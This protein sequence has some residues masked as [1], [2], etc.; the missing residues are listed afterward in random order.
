MTFRQNRA[1]VMFGDTRNVVK[2]LACGSWFYN[3]LVSLPTSRVLYFADKVIESCALMLKYKNQFNLSGWIASQYNGALFTK[4]HTGSSYINPLGHSCGRFHCISAF[5]LIV[6]LIQH[7]WNHR[8]PSQTAQNLIFNGRSRLNLP[9]KI[10]SCLTRMVSKIQDKECKLNLFCLPCISC[11]N[12]WHLD[13]LR[14]SVCRVRNARQTP[15]QNLSKW[16][17]IPQFTPPR[18]QNTLILQSLSCLLETICQT[19][20][21]FGR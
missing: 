11:D 4:C 8:Q 3:V 21:K 5:H 12:S 15:S 14:G 16:I 13:G 9:T 17:E 20:K 2:S 10:L 6:I 1:L 19:R 7:T 18:K